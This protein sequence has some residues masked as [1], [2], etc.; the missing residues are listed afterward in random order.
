LIEHFNGAFPAWLSPV[1][2]VMIPVA[3]RHLD[4]A[5]S[6]AEQLKAEGIRVHVDDS[7]SRMGAKIR[8]ATMQKVPWMLVAGDRDIEQGAVSVRLRTGEDLGAIAVKD[9]IRQAKIVIDAKSL[10]LH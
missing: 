5:K 7:Q 8:E 3:D 4:Y 2:A 1:Q 9:F 10:E 6:V